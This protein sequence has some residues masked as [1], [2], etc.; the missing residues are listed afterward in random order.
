MGIL[1]ITLTKKGKKIYNFL[2]NTFMTYLYIVVVKLKS[3]QYLM[4]L[5]LLKSV[6]YNFEKRCITF[7][8][9]LCFA[10]LFIS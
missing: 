5:N 8:V 1:T 3:H 7:Y 10:T 4:T 2:L 6:G 9:I